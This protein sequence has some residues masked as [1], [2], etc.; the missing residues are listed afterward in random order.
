MNDTQPVIS[1][2][3]RRQASLFRLLGVTQSRRDRLAVL[4]VNIRA[5]T[6]LPF[7]ATL[8]LLIPAAAWMSITRGSDPAAAWMILCPLFSGIAIL[9]GAVLYAP[10]Q[11]SG[12][13]ELLW[14]ACGSGGAFLRLKIS[15]VL[16]AFILLTA[17]PTLVYLGFLPGGMVVG[18]AITALFF[19]TTNAWFLLSAMAWIGTRFQQAWSAGLLGAAF[20][21]VL[22]LTTGGAITSLNLFLNPYLPE[23]QPLLTM[24]RILAIVGGYLLLRAAATRLKR[25]F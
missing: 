13:F 16:I 25:A 7:L 6:G 5:L 20:F 9:L 11:R 21:A 23:A 1:N 10:E 2:W 14:L 3:L 22:Y 12:T 8:A 17:P 24:N 15:A 18:E 19:L 4:Y